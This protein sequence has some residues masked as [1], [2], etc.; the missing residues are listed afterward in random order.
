ML[1]LF[2]ESQT[3]IP[4]GFLKYSFEAVSAV[5]T[6]GLS[7]GVTS[8]LNSFSKALLAFLMFFGRVGPLTLVAA[9]VIQRPTLRGFRLA[10]EDVDIG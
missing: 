8:S 9:F 4:N 7:L 3:T 5:N 6:V 10:Y 2:S 1:L